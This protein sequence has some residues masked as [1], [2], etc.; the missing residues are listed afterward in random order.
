MNPKV[1]EHVKAK[2]TATARKLRRRRAVDRAT[3]AILRLGVNYGRGA[4]VEVL[5]EVSRLELWEC[6]NCHTTTARASTTKTAR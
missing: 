2:V 3:S 5:A 1:D 6:P 4:V